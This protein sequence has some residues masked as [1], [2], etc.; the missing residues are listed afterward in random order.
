MR[1]RI[2]PSLVAAAFA[3]ALVAGCGP[4]DPQL[5]MCQELANKLVGNVAGWE[6]TEQNDGGRSRDID[7]D[8]STTADTSGSISCRYPLDRETRKV[9]TAP[10]QVIL[11]GRRLSTGELF[12]AGTKATGKVLADTADETADRTREL[13][14]EAGEKLRDVADRTLEAGIEGARALQEKLER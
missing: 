11:N 7:I 5:A 1:H 4:D 12:S 9:A 6:R 2:V 10:D 8:Y 3:S 13:A 14:G